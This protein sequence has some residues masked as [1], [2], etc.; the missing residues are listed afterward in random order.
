MFYLHVPMCITCM[1][2]TH[3]GLKRASEPL[4]LELWVVEGSHV[5]AGN[6]TWVLCKSSRCS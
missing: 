2:G 4:K 6:R 3:G 5:G 1:T